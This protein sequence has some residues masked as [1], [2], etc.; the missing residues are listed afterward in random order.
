MSGHAGKKDV[1]DLEVKK[2]GKHLGGGPSAAM[3]AK[4]S[5]DQDFC[6]V[7]CISPGCFE[8]VFKVS[9]DDLRATATR[10]TWCSVHTCG[11]CGTAV[12]LK[13]DQR[14]ILSI[15]SSSIPG[16]DASS[17]TKKLKK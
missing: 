10:R 1:E 3:V 15:S 16:S 11:A 2:V 6:Q 8:P 5:M 12:A 17:S 4:F 9:F 13:C 7:R 14:G